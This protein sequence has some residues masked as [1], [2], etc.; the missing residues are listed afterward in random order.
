MEE[1]SSAGR[2][3]EV[4][5]GLWSREALGRAGVALGRP[6]L[7]TGEELTGRVGGQHGV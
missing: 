5:W 6:A 2:W 7:R 4:S 1:G 3:R